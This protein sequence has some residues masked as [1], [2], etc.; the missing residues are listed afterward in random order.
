MTPFIDTNDFAAQGGEE[1][2][3]ADTQA[4]M[5]GDVICKITSG[6]DTGKF[7]A[8][9]LTATDGR[10]TLANAIGPIAHRISA[11]DPT[12]IQE[13]VLP[14]QDSRFFTFINRCSG[15]RSNNIFYYN[16]TGAG[17]R[18]SINAEA[19]LATKS[20]FAGHGFFFKD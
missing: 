13:R 11:V 2:V 14:N 4:A 12:G 7:G 18:T 19:G 9:N 17:L 6:A 20:Y 16:A 3:F 1:Y 10:Q 8:F 5:T 15:A